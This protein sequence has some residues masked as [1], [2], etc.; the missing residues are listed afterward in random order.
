MHMKAL[1]IRFFLLSVAIALSPEVQYAQQQETTKTD[2][3]K[4][5]SDLKELGGQQQQILSTLNELKQLLV[6]NTARPIPQ[7]PA[8]PSALT[9]QNQSFRGKSGA[10]VAI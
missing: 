5:K 10:S 8:P 4:L 7:P 9:I 6:A 2:I 3:A 1:K